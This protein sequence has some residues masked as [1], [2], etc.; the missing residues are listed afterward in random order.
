[1]SCKH[2]WIDSKYHEYYVCTKCGL[3]TNDYEQYY[4]YKTSKK[5]KG[6]QEKK[7]E[8]MKTAEAVKANQELHKKLIAECVEPLHKHLGA[9]S[10]EYFSK[11]G[12]VSGGLFLALM[13]Y[14][15]KYASQCNETVKTTEHGQ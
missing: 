12:K 15:E 11:T 4:P 9:S 13:Q 5:M 1:M 7:A 10:I 6:K 14:A 8:L 3:E 2:F